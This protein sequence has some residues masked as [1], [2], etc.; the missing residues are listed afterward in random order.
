M[1]R[2]EILK[3]D[4]ISF[5]SHRPE[6]A[7]SQ[8]F[9][10]SKD[11]WFRPT[12]LKTGPDGALWIA[13]FYRLVLEHPE[14]IP[15]DVEQKLKLRSGSDRGRLYRVYPT[16][17]TPRDIPKLSNKTIP[18]LVAALDSPNGWKRDTAQ[19]IL[20]NQNDQSTVTYLEALLR[21]TKNPKA[22]LH[23]LYT[24]DGINKISK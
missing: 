6:Q 13:D 15:D 8:E 24:L 5:L 7:G 11:S 14:W 3:P 19:Q 23:A 1:I 17:S 12:I 9:I 10:A 4:G 22:V 16:T 2:R 18:E 20:V 21:K